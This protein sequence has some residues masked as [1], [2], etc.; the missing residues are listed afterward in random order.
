MKDE[1]GLLSNT[2]FFHT[3]AKCLDGLN[4]IILYI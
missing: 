3:A 1:G 2:V 4:I